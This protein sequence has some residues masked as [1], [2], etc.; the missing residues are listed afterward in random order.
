VGEAKRCQRHHSSAASMAACRNQGRPVG[1]RPPDRHSIE[2]HREAG[3][4]WGW[5]LQPAWTATEWAG[6]GGGF[7]LGRVSCFSCRAAEWAFCMCAARQSTG[8]VPRAAR[9]AELTETA[10]W[11]RTRRFTEPCTTRPASHPARAMAHSPHQPRRHKVGDGWRA[12][13]C[14]APPAAEAHAEAALG[15]QGTLQPQRHAA[16][17]ACRKACLR[18]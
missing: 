12:A 2:E 14:G 15:G 9:Q 5:E 6:G 17:P 10:A 13:A 7:T 11:R 1:A 3:A 8:K 18:G 16:R 4:A